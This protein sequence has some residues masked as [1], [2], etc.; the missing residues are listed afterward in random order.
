MRRRAR[1][2]STACRGLVGA[3]ILLRR[4][5]LVRRAALTCSAAALAGRGTALRPAHVRHS[6]RRDGLIVDAARRLEPLLALE[7][8]QR[9]H[10]SRAEP[11]VRPPDV[12]PFLDQD[13]LNL[14]N[15]FLA[16]VQCAGTA[17]SGIQPRS[18][19]RS[20]RHD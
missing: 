19:A 17:A 12:E 16:Q 15:L 5:L 9:A 10:G 2:A 11:T 7:L 6:E 1:V 3:L 18:A 20:C 13:S 4:S 14:N 8:R